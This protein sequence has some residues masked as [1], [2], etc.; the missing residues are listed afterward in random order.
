MPAAAAAVL[1]PAVDRAVDALRELQ[2]GFY[3][4]QQLGTGRVDYTDA[5]GARVSLPLDQAAAEYM[6]LLR[7]AT[8]G[9]GSNRR[10]RQA[11]TNTLLVQH[12]GHVPHDLALVGYL[13]LLELLADPPMLRRTLYAAGSA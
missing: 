6:R 10:E 7:N 9:H 3:L 2:D 13:Y 8:H 11:L 12:D 5:D 1:M 4:P